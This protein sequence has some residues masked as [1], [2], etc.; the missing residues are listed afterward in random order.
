MATNVSASTTPAR[1]EREL[2]AEHV[3]EPLADE[4]AV[5]LKRESS[6]TPP[7]TGGSTIGS[8]TSARTSDGRGSAPRA[9]THASGTPNT[10][11]ERGRPQRAVDREPERVRAPAGSVRSSHSVA[12]GRALEQPDEREHEERDRDEGEE[13]RD[14]RHPRPR[15]LTWRG[16]GQEPEAL[17]RLLARRREHVVDPRVGEVLRS[18]DAAI[19]AIG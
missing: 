8:T 10:T 12:P 15:R 6:A 11:D 19:G 4:P 7:T 1:A 2:D 17:Q 9:S 5:A 3:V 18:R 13:H 14:E 16:G